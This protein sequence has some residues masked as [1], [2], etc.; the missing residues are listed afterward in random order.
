MHNVTL[1]PG[2]KEPSHTVPTTLEAIFETIINDPVLASITEQLRGMTAIDYNRRKKDLLQSFTPSGTFTYRNANSLIEHNGVF[3]YD[4]DKLS[5]EQVEE[6]REKAANWP[7][8][9]G[10]FTSPSENGVKLFIK[11]AVRPHNNNQHKRD[12]ELFKE[13]VDSY[14]GM[15]S[16]NDG[17]VK[18]VCRLCFIGHDANAYLNLESEVLEV[19]DGRRHDANL[20]RS[21]SL[22]SA[23]KSPEEIV[24]ITA[25]QSGGLPLEEL[26]SAAR[27]AS[28]K[29]GR[30]QEGEV[31]L[32]GE[33]FIINQRGHRV[34][35]S[36]VNAELA[37][38]RLGYRLHWNEFSNRVEHDD[39]TPWQDDETSTFLGDC[40]RHFGFV[41]A[42]PLARHARVTKAKE[43]RVHPIKDYFASIPEWD[44]VERLD[45]G[46]E[47]YLGCD[48]A[49]DIANATFALLIEAAVARALSEHKDGIKFD[50]CPILRGPQGAGKDTFFEIMGGEFFGVCPPLNSF[51][52][53]RDLL[54][55]SRGK[56]WM[57]IPELSNK[58][59]DE[60]RSKQLFS[61]RIDR[62]RKVYAEE[63]EERVR[64]FVFGSGSNK[65]L[66][67]KD[68]NSEYRRYPI[69]H[70]TRL[71]EEALRRDRDQLYSEA[72]VRFQP[73]VTH[74][75]LDPGLWEEAQRVTEDAIELNSQERSI[76]EL[77]HDYELKDKTT[78][79]YKE[80]KAQLKDDYD[81][82]L[83]DNTAFA[84]W[85]ES[86]GWK[87]GS[88]R[89]P[90]YYRSSSA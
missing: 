83:W 37:L 49:V 45:T 71:D 21:M 15:A 65:A 8:T 36:V 25:P 18:D 11:T 4:F 29:A 58:K 76:M 64:K 60:S 1:F 87:K 17:Q 23:G 7:Y 52:L 3:H 40:E 78:F 70:V 22:A 28:L 26:E 24:A 67:L 55:Q 85:A 51:N 2:T 59:V 30:K 81:E 68:A 19:M 73:N 48:K 42:Q 47:V 88:K 46:A 79:T 80:F 56:W 31:L 50:Y 10:I 27:T 74:L 89:D 75:T 9:L 33:G 34:R 62:A 32:D 5:L 90:S 61:D 20:K 69:I 54:E 39:N 72:L 53:S 14:F 35:E 44:G 66:D 41:P 63:P 6:M 43:R 16:K 84:K 77:F 86:F 13:E 82:R 38:D 57:Y 12:W